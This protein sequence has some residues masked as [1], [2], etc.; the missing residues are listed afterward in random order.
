MCSVYRRKYLLNNLNARMTQIERRENMKGYLFIT[1]YLI[2]FTAFIAIPLAFSLFS[3]FTYYNITAV[4][5][6]YGAGNYTSL[7]TGDKYFWKSLY[8]TLYYVV[9]SVPL[10]IIVSM[11]LALLLNLKVKGMKLFRTV[12]YLPSVLSGVAVFLLW[13]WIFDPN[14]GLLNNGLALLGIHGPAWLFDAATTKPAMIIMRLWGTGSTTIILLAALQGVSKDL[15]EAGDIDGAKGFKKFFYITLP[16]ISPTIFFVMITGISSAFQIFDQAYIMTDGTG[17]PSQSLLFYNFYLFNT[18]F[19]DML[20]GKASAM[21]W[22]LF[23]IIMLFT[24]I[25]TVASR[26]WVHYEGGK[27]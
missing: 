13:Q 11:A 4:Q 22:I 9:F 16:M 25:Q 19:Q 14:A 26:K 24:I 15:Y 7:F 5:K 20:M 8:N 23:I 3:S 27:E 18:A 12:Y 2:G 21:A 17:G 10:V 6:W 1:P